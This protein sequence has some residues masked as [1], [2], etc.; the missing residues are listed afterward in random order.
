[1]RTSVLLVLTL[2]VA[3]A[4]ALAQATT[5]SRLSPSGQ[6]PVLVNPRVAPHTTLLCN[7][8]YAA[9]ASGVTHGA[10]WSAEY[11]T[12]ACLAQARE[13]GRANRFH[14]DARLP[15]ADAAQLEDYRRSGYDRGHMALSGDMPGAA[16]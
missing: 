10:L 13:T 5:C 11:P 3:S 6:L 12:A 1:M 4:A 9:L 14:P 7:D 2:F 8:A 15:Y 16:A